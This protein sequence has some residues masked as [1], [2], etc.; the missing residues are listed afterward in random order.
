[1]YYQVTQI[2][3]AN[4]PRIQKLRNM[5][6]LKVMGEILDEK[7]LNITELYHLIYAAATVIT[8][9]INGMG[10]YRLQTRRSTTPPR[11]RRIQGSIN[12]IRK[13]LSGLVGI[14]RDNR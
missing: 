12:G 1:M 3:I 6:K 4:R 13:E 14:Q 9:G 10:V 7:D 11:V 5:F 2:T 8:E